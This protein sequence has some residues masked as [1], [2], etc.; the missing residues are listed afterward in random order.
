MNEYSNCASLSIAQPNHPKILSIPVLQAQKYIMFTAQGINFVY[1][2]RRVKD[3]LILNHEVVAL[4]LE[5]K[6]K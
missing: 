4:V 3:Y 5:A 6:V 1:N 2:K